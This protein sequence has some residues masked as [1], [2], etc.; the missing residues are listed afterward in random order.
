MKKL[1]AIVWLFW[2]LASCTTGKDYQRAL[3]SW[4]NFDIFT[5]SE[6]YQR[7]LDSW[8]GYDIENLVKRW[9]Y[10]TNV[11]EMSNGNTIYAFNRLDERQSILVEY[12]APLI[13][14]QICVDSTSLLCLESIQNRSRLLPDNP[15]LTPFN[16]KTGLT[17]L[18]EYIS[19]AYDNEAGDQPLNSLCETIFEVNIGNSIVH[20][21]YRGDDCY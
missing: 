9:G 13:P 15:Q 5:T 1:P 12:A 16:S 2:M 6:D 3:G 21:S 17:Y 11:F 18:P 7:V 14:S 8:L 4:L 19:L 10:P 20:W